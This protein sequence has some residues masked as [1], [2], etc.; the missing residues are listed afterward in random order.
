MALD[1]TKTKGTKASQDDRHEIWGGRRNSTSRSRGVRGWCPAM[2]PG[3]LA[4]SP[5]FDKQKL[6]AFVVHFVWAHKTFSA[7]AKRTFFNATSFLLPVFSFQFPAARRFPRPS[8]SPSAIAGRCCSF[9]QLPHCTI[10]T[11]CSAFR[12]VFGFRLWPSSR[13]R[14]V[15]LGHS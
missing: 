7:N 6:L 2:L 12:Q 3:R 11:R 14:G 5:A 4:L 13:R 15:G 1:L 8:F 9:R 10:G